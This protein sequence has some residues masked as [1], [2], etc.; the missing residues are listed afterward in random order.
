MGN[1]NSATS[2]ALSGQR[3]LVG[4][5]EEPQPQYVVSMQRK[6]STKPEVVSVWAYPTEQQGENEKPLCDDHTF[7]DYIQRTKYKIRSNSNIAWHEDQR[8][9]A[10]ADHVA[11]G[12]NIKENERDPFA[13]YIQ[14]ARKKLRLRTLSRNIGS[15]KRGP[16]H[17]H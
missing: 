14:N 5:I 13:D 9:P 8:D 10:H 16:G 4:S 12:T 1:K 6:H 11:H 2:K 15:F 3:A 7:S 17:T